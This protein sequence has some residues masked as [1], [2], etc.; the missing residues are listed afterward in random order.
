MRVLVVGSGGFIGRR[1]VARLL[2][3]SIDVR[4]ATSQQSGGI[5]PAT[6]LLSPSFA[7]P[8]GTSAVVYLAQS[9]HYRQTPTLAQH[10]LNVNVVSAVR[11]A[12]LARAAGVR[13]FLYA[14]TGSVYAPSF[15]PLVETAPVR[16]DGWY[17]LSKVMAEEALALFRNDLDMTVVRPFGVYGPGQSSMLVAR[18]IAAVGSGEEITLQRHPHAAD[19]RDGL[20]ISLCYVDDAVRI[21]ESLVHGAGPPV[22]NL[23]G[24]K[25]VSIRELAETIGQVLGRSPKL[26]LVDRVREGDLIADISRLRTAVSA[27]EFTPLPQGICQTVAWSRH[28]EAA[29]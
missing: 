8:A 20:R 29:A 17:S 24:P 22:L 23:A 21:L 10:L 1:L 3:A 15:E 27:L 6:G 19:D 18:L 26:Q 2:S 25:A 7:V 28:A 5:D 13:H 14:S 11:V 16:R 4:Q 12:E 9:P